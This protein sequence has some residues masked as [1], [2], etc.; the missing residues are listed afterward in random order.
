[1]ILIEHNMFQSSLV[2]E[3][4]SKTF[5]E[6]KKTLIDEYTIHM[7]FNSFEEITKLSEESHRKW[8][9]KQ[10]I[11]S[12]AKDII[13]KTVDDL[14]DNQIDEILLYFKISEIIT[15]KKCDAQIALVAKFLYNRVR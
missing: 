4:K 2:E 3:I 14:T 1:M 10:L 12:I 5:D 11:T 8:E 9:F 13:H 15:I 6:F 7:N